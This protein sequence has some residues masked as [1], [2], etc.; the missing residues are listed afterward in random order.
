MRITMLI[1]AIL[2]SACSTPQQLVES[3]D[4]STHKLARA[5]EQA[6]GCIARNAESAA[7]A[8]M[9]SVRTYDR[10][11]SYE[12]VARSG[13]DT[14]LAYVQIDPDPPGSRATLWLRSAWFVGKG[15]LAA[16]MM[17]GC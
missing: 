2:I 13:P 6:A 14:T 9:A 8:L 11:G 5:P 7:T 15:E 4:R 16:T 3:G 1:A 10:P 12:V 17:K